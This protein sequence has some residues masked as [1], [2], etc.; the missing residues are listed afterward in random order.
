MKDA[1]RAVPPEINWER[2]WAIH[3]ALFVASFVIYAIFRAMWSTTESA[4]HVK[5]VHGSI[6][7]SF[8][9]L[10]VLAAAAFGTASWLQP[11]WRSRDAGRVATAVWFAV[12]LGYMLAF[13]CPK[14]LL[15]V[16]VAFFPFCLGALIGHNIGRFHHP[17][18][19]DGIEMDLDD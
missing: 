10:L 6:L 5:D 15:F 16:G 18:H 1:L 8:T 9:V 17:A 12:S 14:V 19:W 3:G 4:D 13:G 11:R 2:R 7:G